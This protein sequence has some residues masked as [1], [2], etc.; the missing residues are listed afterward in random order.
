[1]AAD[2]SVYINSGENCC[3]GHQAVS[4]TIRVRIA[5]DADDIITI[6][7]GTNSCGFHVEHQS[8]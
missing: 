3:A 2:I 5:V 4:M 8:F 1:M 6:A 7:L